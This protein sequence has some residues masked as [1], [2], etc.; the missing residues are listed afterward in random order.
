MVSPLDL[1]LFHFSIGCD[2]ICM[3]VPTKPMDGILRISGGY[4]NKLIV[5]S[6]VV[7]IDAA[8]YLLLYAVVVAILD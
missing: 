6:A 7:I 5:V 2:S 3:S 4:M 1:D 8:F